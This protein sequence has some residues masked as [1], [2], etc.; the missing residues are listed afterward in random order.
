MERW[1]QKKQRRRGVYVSPITKP[2]D[3]EKPKEKKVKDD[4]IDHHLFGVTHGMCLYNRRKYK[5]LISCTF[6][7]I[8]F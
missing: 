7:I 1:K 5:M 8:R 2:F 6:V 4:L 3:F